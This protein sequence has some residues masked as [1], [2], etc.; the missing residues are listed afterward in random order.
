M[1]FLRDI[2]IIRQPKQSC[3]LK[4]SCSAMIQWL[5]W[6]MFLELPH[7]AFRRSCPVGAD[8]L[9]LG[10]REQTKLAVCIGNFKHLA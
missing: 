4:H 10:D 2:K 7:T 6:F 3:T 5:L 9:L 1:Y 8:I